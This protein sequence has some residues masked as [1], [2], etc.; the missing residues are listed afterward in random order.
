MTSTVPPVFRIAPTTK[1]GIMLLTALLTTIVWLICDDIYDRIIVMLAQH[2]RA[3]R[4]VNFE[5][6]LRWDRFARLIKNN[7]GDSIIFTTREVS[8]ETERWTITIR[9]ASTE[10]EK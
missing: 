10:T 1:R 2:N 8:N 6:Q 9:E 7:R 3:R 5:A 4:L